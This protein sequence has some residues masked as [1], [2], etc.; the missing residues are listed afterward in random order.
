VN[1]PPELVQQPQWPLSLRGRSCGSARETWGLTSDT[2]YKKV[3]R[4]GIEHQNPNVRRPGHQS[5]LRNAYPGRAQV[6]M[7]FH[8]ADE[9]RVRPPY[10]FAPHKR[11]RL[12][13]WNEQDYGNHWLRP[14]RCREHRMSCQV[15]PNIGLGVC[16]RGWIR[17]FYAGLDRRSS[18]RIGIALFRRRWSFHVFTLAVAE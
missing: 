8:R 12:A 1:Q 14:I 11:T 7:H 5:R 6:P 17:S 2:A 9:G 3:T 16:C 13:R 15:L 18:R 10:R 4:L